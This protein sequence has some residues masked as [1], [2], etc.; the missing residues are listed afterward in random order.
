M[1]SRQKFLSFIDEGTPFPSGDAKIPTNWSALATAVI[2][3]MYKCFT[4]YIVT[5]HIGLKTSNLSD[6]KNK[7]KITIRF[8]KESLN[9]E[10]GVIAG[11]TLAFNGV[12]ENS[13][14][15]VLH[16][17]LMMWAEIGPALLQGIADIAD[18]CHTISDVSDSMFSATLPRQYHV[19]DLIEKELQFYS[20]NTCVFERSIQRGRAMLT[21]P[22]P[23]C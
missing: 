16:M 8:T 23:M 19:K 3:N 21:P 13:S 12:H 10:G 9:D 17:H 18:V 1:H 5:I 22:D 15:G 4:Y 7:S 6:A 14:R 20:T 11:H 2:K